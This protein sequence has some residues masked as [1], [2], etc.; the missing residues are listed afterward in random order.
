MLQLC[1][2]GDYDAAATSILRAYASEIFRF[3]YARSRDQDIASEAFSQFTEDLW[4]GLPNFQWKCS[5]RTWAYAV[6]RHAASRAMHAAR[7]N[8]LHVPFSQASE[9]AKLEQ[10]V[11][12]ETLNYMKTEVRGRLEKLRETLADEDQALLL[13]RVNRQLSWKDIAQVVLY[14][15]QEISAAALNQEAARLRKR[16]Q[17]LK[18]KLRKWS[19]GDESQ[20]SES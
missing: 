20:P 16:F 14:D 10:R 9:F 12:T 6:A 5:A 7:K 13:L 15:G 17:L 18:E 8:R 1:E 11:R 19:H 4:R 2:K 3:I